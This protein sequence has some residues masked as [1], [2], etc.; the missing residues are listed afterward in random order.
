VL[1]N[2]L[3]AQTTPAS[4]P[5]QWK[6]YTVKDEEFSVMFPVLPAMMSDTVFFLP[7]TNKHRVERTLMTTAN[8]VLY[9]VFAREN[10]KPQQSLADF[11]G[12][13]T[14]MRK[15]ETIAERAVEINGFAGREVTPVDKNQH[16]I[17]RFF[18]TKKHLYRFRVNGADETNAGVK[19]FLSSIMLGEKTEGIEVSDG[20]G[21]VDESS[22]D[23]PIYNRNEVDMKVRITMKRPPQYSEA[24]RQH[25]ITGT[26]ILKAVL[27]STGQVTR[28]I[29]V[30]GLPDGLT[31]RSIA[32]ARMIEFVPA[33]KNGKPVSMW[34]DLEYSFS[35]Y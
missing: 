12:E 3:R 29:V 11:I 2:I 13:Q 28:I 4:D 24:A 14:A 8:G 17:E 33:M 25:R 22:L 6:R 7:P 9:F 16:M 18:A 31:E 35:L 27:S 23:E 34:M 1:G 26:V 5:A 32:A 20:P 10:V 19:Q 15:P 21:A 30:S